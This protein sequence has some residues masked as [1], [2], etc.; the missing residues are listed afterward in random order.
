MAFGRSI[1]GRVGSDIKVSVDGNPLY[2]VGG[3]TLYWGG[4]TAQSGTVQLNADGTTST[5]SDLALITGAG[6]LDVIE[7]GEKFL[8]F[9]T[10]VCRVSG[11]SYDGYF[12]PYGSS[13]S[14]GTLLKTRGDMYILNESVHEADAENAK[15]IEG[16]LLYRHR[17]LANFYKIATITISATGGT[18]TISYKG[19]T[20][21]ALAYNASAS[22]VQTAVQGLST[23]GSGNATVSLSGSVYTVTLAD[24]LSPYG[25]ITTDPASLTGGS[26]TAVVADKADTSAG[27][28]QAEFEA[29][30]PTVRLVNELNS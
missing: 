19:Q 7:D 3:V 4:V 27:P 25:E 1:L 26:Q 9:G 23:V 28:T 5:I 15:A 22:T 30:F 12:A 8:R 21:S 20:T 11:G 10:V 29:A 18:F 14:G 13:V 2:K 6:W 16:G 17:I 24:A